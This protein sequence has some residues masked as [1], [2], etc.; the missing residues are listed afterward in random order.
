MWGTQIVG[1]GAYSYSNT[2]GK[3]F[4]WMLTGFSPR[5]QAISVYIMS[6]FAK[7]GAQM[8]KLGRYKTGKSCLYIRRLS[9]VD[10]NVL[11]DLISASIRHLRNSYTTK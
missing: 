5:K 11:Q 1:F 7:F 3:D 8:K 9:D 6:G 10:E 2:A 4:E